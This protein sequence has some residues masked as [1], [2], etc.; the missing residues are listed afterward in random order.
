[1]RTARLSTVT[2]IALLAVAA[3]AAGPAKADYH[4]VKITEIAGEAGSD[5][6]SY[7]ELQMY[8]PGQNQMNGHKLTVWDADG[9]V[10]G[11]PV[12]VGSL[13]LIGTN[14]PNGESQRTVLVGDTG[15]NGRDFT[16]DLTPYFDDDIGGLTDA[17]AVCFE[18]VDCVSWGGDAFTGAANL[19]DPTTPFGGGLT[20]LLGVTA[21]HRTIARGCPTALDPADDSNDAAADFTTATPTPRPNAATPTE[22]LCKTPADPVVTKKKCKKGQKLVKRKGKKRCVKKKKRKRKR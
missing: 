7:V 21:H 18:T 6:Q 22:T 10:L 19:P 14:P 12:P 8:S 1:M 2:A 4:V 9:L 20:N 16:V 17:G 15:V 3:F 11:Q 13:N 5:N